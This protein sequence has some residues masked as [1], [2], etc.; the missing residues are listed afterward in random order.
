MARKSPA[1]IEETVVDSDLVA[2]FDLLAQF[3]Y[4]DRHGVASSLSTDSP[5]TPGS[6]H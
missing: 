1:P 4:E 6:Q 5:P 2:F 3:D